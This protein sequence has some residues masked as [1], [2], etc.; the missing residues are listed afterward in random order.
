MKNEL[1]PLSIGQRLVAYA[2]QKY[3]GSPVNNIGGLILFEDSLDCDLLTKAI[4]ICVQR[5]D[6]LHLRMQQ[7]RKLFLNAEI[8]MN[9]IIQQYVSEIEKVEVGFH[10]FSGCTTQEMEDTILRWNR[11]PIDI[12]DFPLYEFKIIKAPD[13]RTGV[14]SK[15]HHIIT[16]AWNNTLITKEIIEIYNALLRSDELPKPLNSF[17]SYLKSEEA[18]LKSPQYEVD[19]DFWMNIYD[20]KPAATVL[21]GKGKKSKTGATMRFNTMIGLE[22][23]KAI[24]DFCIQN[25]ISPVSLFTLLVSMCISHYTGSQETNIAC[26]VMFRSTLKEK[27]TCGPMVNFQLVR[28]FFD[29]N[30]TFID[31]CREMDH[32]RLVS[33][34]HT[35]YPNLHLLKSIFK[36][37]H[38][39]ELTGAFV[40]MVPAKIETKDNMKFEARWLHS[41]Y[42]ASRF[43][44]YI[45]DIEGTGKYNLQ[46]EYQTDIHSTEFV[47]ELHEKLMAFLYYGIEN[48]SLA[49]KDVFQAS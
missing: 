6:A 8:L 36:K 3:P 28:F 47:K 18:Y 4:E 43:C 1:F 44:L 15:V 27:T 20:T 26:P 46:Y 21:G 7:K 37:Y 34:R 12:F 31:S 24:N 19:R 11:I 25:K 42:F 23:S 40:S 48:P 39:S 22:R 16:D 33:M 32:Q 49:M 5:N 17:L 9:D 10:D 2:G 30:K 38:I 41:G 35:R 14:F 45:M 29:S 13:G